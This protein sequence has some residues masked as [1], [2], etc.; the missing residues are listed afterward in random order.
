MAIQNSRVV[1]YTRPDCHLCRAARE[2]VQEI[3]GDDWLELDVD[4][5]GVHTGDGRQAARAYGELVPVL[6]VDG[7]RAGY[8]YIDAD[9]LVGALNR[10][11]T[12]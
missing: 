8:W 10:P 6:E 9:L 3:C 12:P 4:Q 1:L 7:R 2:A 11:I 5:P